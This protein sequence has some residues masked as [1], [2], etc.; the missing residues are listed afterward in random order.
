MKYVGHEVSG[1]WPWLRGYSP[2]VG[3][4]L[5]RVNEEARLIALFC[6]P[7]CLLHSSSQPE[8]DIIMLR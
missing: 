8:I 3:R 2:S 7:S 4:P 1:W 5:A 6:V